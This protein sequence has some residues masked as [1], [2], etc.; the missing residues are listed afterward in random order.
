MYTRV[1]L[2]YT[3]GTR[4]RHPLGVRN[5]LNNYFAMYTRVT[6]SHIYVELASPS[7][8]VLGII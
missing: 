4:I 1:A 5:Y 6:R 2:P 7:Y 8:L 3:R